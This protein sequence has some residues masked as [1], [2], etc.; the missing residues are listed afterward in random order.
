M[1]YLPLNSKLFGHS[2]AEPLEI[3]LKKGIGLFLAGLVVIVI[4]EICIAG[5]HEN[6]VNPVCTM[7][8]FRPIPSGSKFNL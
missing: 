1:V 5:S 4:I 2:P 3:V 8:S 7:E 6:L